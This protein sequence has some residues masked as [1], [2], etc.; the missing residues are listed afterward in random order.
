M[1]APGKALYKIADL[2][3]IELK[4]YISG[5]QL[6]NIKLGQKVKV[7]ID[8]DKKENKE[9]IGEISW[10]SSKAEFTPKLI[11]TKDERVNMVYSIKIK[12]INDGYL[13]IGMPG[14][15]LFN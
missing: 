9:Y 2:S 7:L 15:V 1:T 14:E 5:D 3:T 8:K 4:A 13:K 6:P 10:I 11:Q 12:V